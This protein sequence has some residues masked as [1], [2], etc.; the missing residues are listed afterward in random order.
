MSIQQ[1]HLYTSVI[2]FFVLSDITRSWKQFYFERSLAHWTLSTSE[3]TKNYI[4]HWDTA[5]IVV[6]VVIS[7]QMSGSYFSPLKVHVA[8]I[9]QNT[10]SKASSLPSPTH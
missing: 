10:F 7:Y 1:T 3:G 8:R 6:V 5:I 9:Y 4:H 2:F